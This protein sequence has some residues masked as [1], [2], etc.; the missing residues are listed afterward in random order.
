M[1]V[2]ESQKS[3]WIRIVLMIVCVVGFVVL[4]VVLFLY[5]YPSPLI[6]LMVKT[7]YPKD[8]YPLLYKTPTTVVVNESAASG[9][10]YEANGVNYNSPWGEVDEM[11]ESGDSVGFKFADDRSVLIFGTDV[12]ANLVKP[13]LA[14]VTDYEK[15]LFVNVFG[16][17]ALSNDYELRRHVLF[18][19]ASSM[20]FVMS[21][22]TAVST[23]SLLNL[24]VASA[25]YV[26]DDE[27]EIV[28]FTANN[29]KGFW[30]DRQ[31]E[32]GTILITMY[33]LNNNDLPYEMSIKG[34]KQEIE[35]ILNSVVIELK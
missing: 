11:I 8:S 35:A 4:P 31:D 30:F 28:A 33:P 21:P 6:T 10:D 23:Y 19:D 12:S 15:E 20:K 1:N 32:V 9:P 17:D 5:F 25:M 22:A 27:G 14:E 24:K 26:Q 2:E 7:S 13:F 16:E 29:I 34:T 18:S 3:P